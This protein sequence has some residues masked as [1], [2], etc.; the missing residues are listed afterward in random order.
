MG[1]PTLKP[2]LA[3]VMM[4]NHNNSGLDYFRSGFGGMPPGY[5][6]YL[7]KAMQLLLGGLCFL[8]CM[9]EVNTSHVYTCM[10]AT[11]EAHPLLPTIEDG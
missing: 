4:A 6:S 11:A 8:V 5:R 10:E 9:I 7:G 2:A 1:A 3:P